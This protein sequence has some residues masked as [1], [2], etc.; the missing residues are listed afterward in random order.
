MQEQQLKIDS[1]TTALNQL[2]ISH[3]Q[4]DGYRMSNKLFVELN[5][6][7]GI[8]LNQNDPNPFAEQTRI[9]YEVPDEIQD[10]KIIFY[11]NDGGILK[12]VIISDREKEV[13]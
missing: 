12:T 4:E 3:D 8:I 11:N 1:L 10:A 13:L 7:N 2:T 9:T 6:M 5:A